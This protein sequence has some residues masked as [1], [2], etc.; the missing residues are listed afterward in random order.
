MESWLGSSLVVSGSTVRG[1]QGGKGW[2]PDPFQ[3]V[4]IDAMDGGSG[5]AAHASVPGGVV[6]TIDSTI[7][8]GLP[9]ATGCN[10]G[11]PGAAIGPTD[12]QVIAWNGAVLTLDLAS[13]LRE[14]RIGSLTIG[15]G[16]VGTSALPILGAT[17]SSFVL[18]AG[19]ATSFVAPRWTIV[20]LGTMGVP[21]SSFAAAVSHLPPGVAGIAVAMQVAGCAGTQCVLGGGGTLVVLDSTF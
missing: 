8:G 20:A 4:C 21:T 19:F 7:E 10:P 9:G 12:A 14:G 17:P 6:R 1:G 18:P 2:G 15:D 5:I 16:A 11:S 13:P 3:G